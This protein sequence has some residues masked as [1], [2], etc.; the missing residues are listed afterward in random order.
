MKNLTKLTLAF[1]LGLMAFYVP[2][3]SATGAFDA[4]T[5]AANFTDLSSALGFIYAAVAV[6][7]IFMLGGDIILKK[8]GWK[9]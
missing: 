5:A 7:G 6:V 3:A 4:I 1:L 9:K 8:L 2:T